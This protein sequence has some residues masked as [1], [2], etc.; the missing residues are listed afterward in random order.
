MF[1]EG[2]TIEGHG[3]DEN[4]VGVG[5]LC[6]VHKYVTIYRT[7]LNS[8]LIGLFKS[9]L[10]WGNNF[11]FT[12]KCVIDNMAMTNVVWGKNIYRMKKNDIWYMVLV[13]ANI[14]PVANSK[15]Q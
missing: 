10:L 14:I 5:S 6:K 1:C 2:L 8:V 11:F 4:N 12:I 3:N 13:V 9:T 15:I 7:C